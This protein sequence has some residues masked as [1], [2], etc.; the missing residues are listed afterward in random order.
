M[1]KLLLISVIV[2]TLAIPIRAAR[3]PHPARALKRAV[4]GFAGFALFYLF[5]L[6]FIYPRLF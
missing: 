5:S 2:A 1:Q 4:A 6:R 3:D